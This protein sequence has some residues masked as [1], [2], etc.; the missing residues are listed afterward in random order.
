MVQSI[1]ADA[2]ARLE[3]FSQDKTRYT[4]TLEN[5]LIQGLLALL[6]KNVVL[7]VRKADI[8]LIKVAR[9]LFP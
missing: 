9:T 5:L 4:A 8:P 2:R 7:R 1:F 3:A 6:D